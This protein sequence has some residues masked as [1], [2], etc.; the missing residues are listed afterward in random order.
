MVPRSR[1]FCLPSGTR[2]LGAP[3]ANL[4]GWG[5]RA[6]HWR[7]PTLGKPRVSASLIL[8]QRSPLAYGHPFRALISPVLTTPPREASNW[9]WSR[10]LLFGVVRALPRRAHAHGEGDRLPPRWL[11][12]P[13]IALN[14]AS[15][16]T[17]FRCAIRLGV[18]WVKR[19]MLAPQRPRPQWLAVTSPRWAPSAICGVSVLRTTGRRR[20]S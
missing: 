10:L 15:R 11:R 4:G 16:C 19:A 2:G 1:P 3:G 8:F 13:Q 9:T 18:W 14:V 17:R 5:A 6:S 12:F 7:R 20:V